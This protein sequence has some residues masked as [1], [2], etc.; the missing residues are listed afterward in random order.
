MLTKR[1]W[2]IAFFQTHLSLLNFP[3]YLVNVAS[4]VSVVSSFSDGGHSDFLSFSGGLYSCKYDSFCKRI[5]LPCRSWSWQWSH[6]VKVLK[7]E[8]HFP[9][10]GCCFISWMVYCSFEREDCLEGMTFWCDCSCSFCFLVRFLTDQTNTL[11]IALSKCQEEESESC[12][13]LWKQDIRKKHRPHF[14][15]RDCWNWWSRKALLSSLS[16]IPVI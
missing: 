9:S 5:T 3:L 4:L 16:Q 12:A 1:P 10:D 15:Y 14:L 2:D 6:F 8:T 13:L 11:S 7:L